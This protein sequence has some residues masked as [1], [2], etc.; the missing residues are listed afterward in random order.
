MKSPQA[1]L[2]ATGLLVLL[3]AA[4]DADLTQVDNPWPTQ[5]GGSG[6]WNLYDTGSGKKGIMEY[7]Y[8]QGHFTR[9]DDAADQLWQD[10]RGTTTAQAKFAG[11]D[12]NLYWDDGTTL[13]FLF[14]QRATVN[15]LWDGGPSVSFDIGK[16]V[17]VRWVDDTTASGGVWASS[18]PSKTL[19]QG[20]P[21]PDEDHMVTFLVT[22]RNIYDSADPYEPVYWEEFTDG[23]RYV[24][25]FEDLPFFDPQCQNPW[26][27]KDYQDL[28]VEVTTVH[29]IPAP[30]AIGLGILGLGLIGWYMRRFA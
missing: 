16:G 22:G 14:F 21:L 10:G 11:Y 9:V 17:T 4:A 12:Q 18:D 30:A 29:P 7:L 8:G 23:P 1:V 5:P 15:P 24:I 28:V 2:A 19:Y 25:A 27:D 3:A 20:Q 13:H 6:E 26:S